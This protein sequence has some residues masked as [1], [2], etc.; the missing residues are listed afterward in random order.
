MGNPVRQWGEKEWEGY[1]NSLMAT[2][3]SLLNQSY[4]RIPDIGGD[5]G[6][7]GVA[8]S[9]DA[10]Q[11]YAD[12]NTKNHKE[13]VK[14]QKNKI[15]EDLLKLDTNQTWWVSFLGTQ[16]IIRWTLL[17]PVVADK[18]VLAYGR[19]K[20]R[21][22]VAKN[23]A[24][25]DPKLEVFVKSAEDFPNALMI[26]REPRLP[27][28]CAATVD[29]TQIAAFTQQYP[30]FVKLLD[31]KLKKVLDIQ[32]DAERIKFRDLLLRRHLVG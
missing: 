11:C 2:H 31:D 21:E 23:L 18:A 22:L 19:K 7:E 13:L 28:G 26:A 29:A 1:A 30:Q 24:F 12:Q 14:K 32:T 10:Y 20:G 16:K 25:I 27:K 6:L 5:N 4:Q 3:H 8:D 9:G 17:V 15:E